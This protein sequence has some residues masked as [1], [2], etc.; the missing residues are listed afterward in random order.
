MGRPGISLDRLLGETH[1]GELPC[2]HQ[3]NT[4]PGLRKIVETLQAV[5]EMER[6]PAQIVVGLNRCRSSALGRVANQHYARQVLGQENIIF[7]REDKPAAEQA[8]NTGI[9]AA[10]GAN[11][12]KLRKDIRP[13]VNILAPM[14]RA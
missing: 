14:M 7:V 2:P 10:G 1:E 12:S 6:V 9:P 8:A 13:F 5:R 4:I 3:R 11:S